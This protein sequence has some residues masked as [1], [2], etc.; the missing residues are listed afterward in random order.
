M[1]DPNPQPFLDVDAFV[2]RPRGVITVRG[3]RHPVYH[4][5]DLT[6]RE[7]LELTRD[8]AA[9]EARPGPSWLARYLP[10]LLRFFAWLLRWPEWITPGEYGQIR[11]M[12][13]QIHRLV[14]S[15]S[16]SAIMRLTLAE[17]G[18]ITVWIQKFSAEEDGRP[19]AAEPK[20]E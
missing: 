19:L 8:A 6:W 3:R 4:P 18:A 20:A 15:L 13:R 10:T 17:I 2:R 12:A 11:R 1:A 9:L 7:Y 14:P 16:T 5:T